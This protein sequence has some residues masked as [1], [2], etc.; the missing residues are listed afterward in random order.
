V[1]RV[2]PEKGDKTMRDG[3]FFYCFQINTY[4]SA[5]A[6]LYCVHLSETQMLLLRQMPALPGG[7]ADSLMNQAE[8]EHLTWL[9]PN[10]GNMTGRSTI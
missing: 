7:S 5:V 4:L 9:T 10:L 8:G 2:R 1:H 6:I 3:G